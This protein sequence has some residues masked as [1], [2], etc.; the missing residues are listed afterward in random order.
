MRDDDAPLLIVGLGNPGAQYAQTRHN[1]GF[2][3]LDALEM[4]YRLPSGGSWNPEK[5][6]QGE[7]V[8]TNI[9]GRPTIL[10]KPQTYM[11]LSGESLQQVMQFFKIPADNLLVVYDDTAL[12]FGRVRFR[13]QGSAGSH[14]GMKSI[15]QH[16]DGTH[17]IARFRIGIDEPPGV[18]AQK[19][20]VL[21][22]FT[23]MERTYLDELLDNCCRAVAH[24]VTHDTA[25]AANA[26]NGQWLIADLEPLPPPPPTAEADSDTSTPAQEPL[27]GTEETPAPSP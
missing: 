10:L 8:K 15:L 18:I 7:Y 9:E 16:C 22:P 24:W 2:M 20:Y 6:F 11:N 1:I 21:A 26:F 19:N 27:S 13:A 17:A 23:T 25:Q 4:H 12:A 3:C 5:K 14:N